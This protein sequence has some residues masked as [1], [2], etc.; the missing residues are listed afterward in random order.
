M[1]GR[2]EVLKIKS[3][4]FQ[5]TENGNKP[6]KVKS[7]KRVPHTGRE[8]EHVVSLHPKVGGGGGCPETRKQT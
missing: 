5:T 7:F 1:K 3:I 4:Q 8:R 2:T 6:G